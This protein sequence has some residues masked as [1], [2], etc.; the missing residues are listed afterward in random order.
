MKPHEDALI[1]LFHVYKRYGAKNALFDISLDIF[2]NEFLLGVMTL[3]LVSKP[4]ELERI[5]C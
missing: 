3:E 1:R 5:G 2:K 4:S